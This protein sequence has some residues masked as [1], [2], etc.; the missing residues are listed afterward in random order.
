MQTLIARREKEGSSPAGNPFRGRWVLRDERGQYYDHDQY[1]HD[2]QERWEKH[3]EF[4]V[5]IQDDETD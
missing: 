2:L 1:R 4:K 3:G 5:V